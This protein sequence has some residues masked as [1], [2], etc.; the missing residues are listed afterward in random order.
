MAIRFH[1]NA[2]CNGI[3]LQVCKR[4]ILHNGAQ[5]FQ[6]NDGNSCQKS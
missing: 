6:L 5:L 1:S 2:D 4:K 3:V